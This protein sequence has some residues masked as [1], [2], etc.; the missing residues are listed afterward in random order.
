MRRGHRLPVFS[1]AR[2]AP[3]LRLGSGAEAAEL[4]EAGLLLALALVDGAA[5]G[6]DAGVESGSEPLL[7]G[8]E[9]APS[10]APRGRG[11]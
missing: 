7:E 10:S 3:L 2:P 9:L 1:L 8:V 6:G 11:L 4:A 5:D